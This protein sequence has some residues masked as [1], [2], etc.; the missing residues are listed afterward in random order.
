MTQYLLTKDK[1]HN[2]RAGVGSDEST[3]FGVAVGVCSAILGVLI[4]LYISGDE[5]R[6]GRL[7]AFLWAVLV[8]CAI[9]AVY[10]GRK[11]QKL[12][13]DSDRVFDD[14]LKNS[15]TVIV[16]RKSQDS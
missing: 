4:P 7:V 9:L 15:K 14:I 12:R 10:F 13:Q 6:T 8:P 3:M 5:A 11:W 2:I 1:L 16:F